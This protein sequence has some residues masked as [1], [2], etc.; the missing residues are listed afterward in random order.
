MG[1]G[2]ALAAEMDGDG[3]DLGCDAEEVDE[4]VVR[5]G[6]PP[7]S[8]MLDEVS[9]GGTVLTESS[10]GLDPC[11]I[12]RGGRPRNV[13]VLDER[14]PAELEDGFVGGGLREEIEVEG[15]VRVEVR[16]T[17]E[18]LEDAS[19]RLRFLR[20]GRGRARWSSTRAT[21]SSRPTRIRPQRR[22]HFHRRVP[23]EL[24]LLVLLLVAFLLTRFSPRSPSYR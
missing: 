17:G 6:L 1:A 21:T 16:G 10:D 18:A 4:E 2:F 24:I 23:A 19:E 13:E 9:N 14:R 15:A 12:L 3:V 22:N 7:L 20:C 5:K 8:I 11:G